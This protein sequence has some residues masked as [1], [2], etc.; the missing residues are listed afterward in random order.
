MT[1]ERD[2][3]RVRSALDD[4]RFAARIHQIH[5][6]IL[7]R[8]ERA[9]PTRFRVRIRILEFQAGA[10]NAALARKCRGENVKQ[11]SGGSGV[12]RANTV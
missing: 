4:S 5:Q 11:S 12:D 2:R 1:G 8:P 7:H 6:R 10:R 9:S 3:S